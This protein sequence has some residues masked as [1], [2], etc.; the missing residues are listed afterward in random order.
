L[1]KLT[2]REVAAAVDISPSFLSMVER[3]EAD[4]S[5]SRF[6]R[7][8]AFYGI[9]PGE[10]L[11]EDPGGQV[12]PV[13]RLDEGH[14]IDRGPGIIYRLLRNSPAGLQLIHAVFAPHTATRDVLAHDGDDFL[15]VIR[16]SVTLL[17]GEHEVVVRASESTTYDGARP[18]AFRNDAD[19]PAELF[20]LTTKPYW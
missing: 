10:L 2:L 19:E 1:R 4:I 5:V 3:G 16:G 6:A 7:L 14:S 18:H 20:A 9:R 12:P 11:L 8:A 13:T 15:F 17:Y